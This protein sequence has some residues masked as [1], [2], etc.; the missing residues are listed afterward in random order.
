MLDQ[1]SGHSNPLTCRRTVKNLRQVGGRMGGE[2]QSIPASLQ[3]VL[4]SILIFSLYSLNI[5]E[6]DLSL[7]RL[8]EMLK[9]LKFCSS[10][11]S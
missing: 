2:F 5:H 10:L 1:M 11:N 6:I 8:N 3:N 7:V 9:S 4:S